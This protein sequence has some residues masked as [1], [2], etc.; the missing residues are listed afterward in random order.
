MKGGILIRL[1]LGA[2][3]ALGLSGSMAAGSTMEEADAHFQAQEWEK[4]VAAYEKALAESPADGQGWFRLGRAYQGLEKYD[5]AAEA[6]VKAEKNGFAG[7]PLL[8][9]AASVRIRL[10]QKEQ[11]LDYLEQAVKMGA[12][13]SALNQIPVLSRLEDQPRY[14]G[15]AREAR[16]NQ[17]P[18]TELE[19]YRQFDFWIGEWDVFSTAGQRVGGNRIRKMSNG[20]VLLE[21]WTGAAGSLGQSINYYDSHRKKWVQVWSDSSGGSIPQEGEFREGAMRLSGKH[22]YRN[23]RMDLFRGTWEPL[24][25]GRVRQHLEQSRDGGET[26]YTW[27]DGFYVKRK[28]S[29]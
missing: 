24:P 5:R 16:V 29:K 1:V 17:S 19:I 26:W 23:G 6:Y 3:L 4:A 27:F 18:C 8:L 9:R 20:C 12:G 28:E 22:F 15:I 14:A 21:N 25:D 11:A 13:T 10:E 7:L 2:I